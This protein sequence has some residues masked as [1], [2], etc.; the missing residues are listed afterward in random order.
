M[1]NFLKKSLRQNSPYF[2]R[3]ICLLPP[4]AHFSINAKDSLFK[5]VFRSSNEPDD[6][7]GRKA[8]SIMQKDLLVASPEH[9]FLDV[10]STLAAGRTGCGAAEGAELPT[11]HLSRHVR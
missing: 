2:S 3:G 6:V 9:G 4:Q 7:S 11:E 10:L 8:T 1:L 5:N